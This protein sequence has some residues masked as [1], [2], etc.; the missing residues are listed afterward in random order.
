MINDAAGPLLI[1]ERQS[2]GFLNTSDC[3]ITKAYELKAKHVIHVVG[4][5][6]FDG[7]QNEEQLLYLTYTNALKL[8][9]KH[10]TSSIAFP[11]ISSGLFGF[12]RGKALEVALRAIKDFLATIDMMI[13]LV[14]YDEQSYQLSVE[15]FKRIKSYIDKQ[16]QEE[17]FSN[18]VYHSLDIKYDRVSS[19]KKSK[20]IKDMFDHMDD[21]FASSLFN[22]IDERK[23]DDVYVYKRANIDRKLFSKI[24][25]NVNYQPSKVTAIAFALALELSLDETKDLLNKAG[26]ALSRSS[27]FDLII[28]YFIEHKNYDLYEINQVLFSFEQKVIGENS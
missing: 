9:I 8:A 14:V 12:P 27:K 22:Y 23:L 10:N 28:Q 1:T 26:Y 13:Y 17:E 18:Q 20:S 19:A 11:L 21:S 7:K 3:I 25:S 15:R 6:Y 16:Y 5:I 24:K 4:P 2:F